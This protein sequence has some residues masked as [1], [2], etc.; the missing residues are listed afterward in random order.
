MNRY[1]ASLYT[2]IN[3]REVRQIIQILPVA[4]PSNIRRQ[5]AA[6]ERRKHE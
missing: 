2:R 5:Q 1:I 4:H 6:I 3:G